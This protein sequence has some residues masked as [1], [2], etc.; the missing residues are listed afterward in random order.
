MESYPLVRESLT[1]PSREFAD[2]LFAACPEVVP[3]ARMQSVS[4]DG[5]FDLLVEVPSPTGDPMRRLYLW[6][7]DGVP[8][9]GLGPRWHTHADLWP[10]PGAGVLEQWRIL[11]ELLRA[12]LADEFVLWGQPGKKAAG[13]HEVLDLREPHAMAELMT[14]PYV[15]SRVCI[16]SWGGTADSELGLEDV[17]L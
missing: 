12:I 16:H 13:F 2:R 8:S 11:L 9:L 3:F 10:A 5:P 1:L 7:E 15:E 6:V 14:S 17:K 4:L